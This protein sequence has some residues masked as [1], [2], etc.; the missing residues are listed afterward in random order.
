MCAKSA[1]KIGD[2]TENGIL[3]RGYYTLKITP[4]IYPE[5]RHKIEDCLRAM[6]YKIRG[7]GMDTDLTSCD[8]SFE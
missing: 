5:G 4:A 3:I 1:G 8:I 7:G 6:G 2:K